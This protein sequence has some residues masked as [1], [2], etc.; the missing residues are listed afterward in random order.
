MLLKRLADGFDFSCNVTSCNVTFLQCHSK[1]LA[2]QLAVPE[3][4]IG[5]E[6]YLQHKQLRGGGGVWGGGGRG[7]CPSY[8][9]QCHP[10][11]CV[12]VLSAEKA[13]GPAL[14][15]QKIK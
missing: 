2:A 15:I 12:D 13:K 10:C 11:K 8:L 4:L 9:S 3:Q 7:A 6:Q 1:L 14:S 5:P